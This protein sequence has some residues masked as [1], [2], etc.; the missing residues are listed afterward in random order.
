[1]LR[2]S[3]SVS[4]SVTS[5]GRIIES[6][7]KVS[8]PQDEENMKQPA[9]IVQ[10]IVEDR[11]KTIEPDHHT[12]NATDQRIPID[13]DV[14]VA[15]DNSGD[16]T[17]RISMEKIG[18]SNVA[19]NCIKVEVSDQATNTADLNVRDITLSNTGG[20]T[21]E[22]TDTMEDGDLSDISCTEPLQVIQEIKVEINK[23]KS[24]QIKENEITSRDDKKGEIKDT[25]SNAAITNSILITGEALLKDVGKGDHNSKENLILKAVQQII[26]LPYVKTKIDY[27]KFYL[28]TLFEFFSIVYYCV[29]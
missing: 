15:M 5:L 2:L 16:D 9:Q 27:S 3:E 1:M 28:G 12:G 26:K 7:E 11:V 23:M 8:N 6:E 21:D 20:I 22:Y 13:N 17:R 4:R 18:M 24:K 10:G 19:V 29:V 14:V 25:K